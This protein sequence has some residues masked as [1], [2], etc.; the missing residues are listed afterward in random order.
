L[1]L[2][3]RAAGNLLPAFRSD[4]PDATQAH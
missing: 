4:G 1:T 3:T 2:F